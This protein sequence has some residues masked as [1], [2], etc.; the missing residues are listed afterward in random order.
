MY[1]IFTHIYPRDESN[2]GQYSSTMEHQGTVCWMFLLVSQG[3]VLIA[4]P[5]TKIRRMPGSSEKTV[6]WKLRGSFLVSSGHVKIAS[7]NSGQ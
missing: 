3:V 4:L 6:A 2:V 1:G 5:G 7:V